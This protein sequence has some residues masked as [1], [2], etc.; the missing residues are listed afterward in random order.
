MVWKNSEPWPAGI[1]S[2]T[3]LTMFRI[4]A[5]LFV[6]R[7][8]IYF[9]LSLA[10]SSVVELYFLVRFRLFVLAMRFRMRR[11]RLVI[12]ARSQ[13]VDPIFA[14]FLGSCSNILILDR[15]FK[16]SKNQ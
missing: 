7:E 1:M 11:T 2:P 16:L 14:I 4:M 12:S 6:S 10:S 9:L 13:K 15:I 3:T 8:P 5:L